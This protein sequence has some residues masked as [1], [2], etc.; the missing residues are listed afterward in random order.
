MG[1]DAFGPLGPMNMAELTATES[2]QQAVTQ[3]EAVSPPVVGSDLAEYMG[4][5]P[6]GNYL[7]SAL[8]LANKTVPNAYTVNPDSVVQ[9]VRAKYPGLSFVNYGADTPENNAAMAKDIIGGLGEYGLSFSGNRLT[10]DINQPAVQEMLNTAGIKEGTFV[11]VTQTTAT[12]DWSQ[13]AAGPYQSVSYGAGPMSFADLTPLG[14]AQPA[15]QPAGLSSFES[16]LGSLPVT[17]KT[18]AYAE[19]RI[20]PLTKPISTEQAKQD[21]G[22]YDKPLEAGET[23]RENFNEAFADAAANGLKEFSWKNP[24]TGEVGRYKVAYAQGGMAKSPLASMGKR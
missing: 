7:F 20:A 24:K 22:Y 9:Q 13:P 15:A 12:T 19:P 5:N 23:V 3:A 10:G 14:A 11:P 21:V 16:A 6:Q 4:T 17:T 2:G 8:N 18:P 1:V